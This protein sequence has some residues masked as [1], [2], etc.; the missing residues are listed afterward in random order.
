MQKKS[1]EKATP[2]TNQNQLHVCHWDIFEVLYM[3]CSIILA[4]WTFSPEG[5]YYKSVHSV[6]QTNH[7]FIYFRTRTR[8]FCL[9][10]QIILE[11]L[12]IQDNHLFKCRLLNCDLAK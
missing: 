6:I 9:Q 10:P 7:T 11:P 8:K 2:S 12:P 3:N 1:S 5:I 4:L